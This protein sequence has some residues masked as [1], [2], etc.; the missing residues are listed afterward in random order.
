M[1]FVY[2]DEE[3]TPIPLQ[4]KSRNRINKMLSTK[5]IKA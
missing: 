4:D 3:G 5:L 2:I 1:K